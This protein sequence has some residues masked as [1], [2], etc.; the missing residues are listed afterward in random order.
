MMEYKG[1]TAKVEFDDEADLFHGQVLNIRDVITFQGRSVEELRKEFVNSVEDYLEFCA[2]RGEEPE[3]PYSGR[4]LVRLKPELHR[5][6]AIAAARA[7]ESLN[8]WVV[9]TLE[10]ALL[11]ATATPVRAAEWEGSCL[12]YEENLV[13]A[14]TKVYVGGQGWYAGKW[15]AVIADQHHPAGGSTSIVRKTRVPS[16]RFELGY[17]QLG[18]GYGD[19][20]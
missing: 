18:G 15:N 11:P 5:E 13:S 8:A 2:E 16:R 14:Q 6:F 12:R 1:Y 17:T 4:F 9:Q 7:G 20:T 19:D 3:K 10:R